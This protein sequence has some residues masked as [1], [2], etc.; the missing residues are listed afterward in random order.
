MNKLNQQLPIIREK[1]IKTQPIEDI[2]ELVKTRPSR[3]HIM[4]F[5]G[6]LKHQEKD[7]ISH[8]KYKT[9]PQ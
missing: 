5:D 4:Y 3:D 7:Q 1:K 9:K 8:K 6:G 2:F